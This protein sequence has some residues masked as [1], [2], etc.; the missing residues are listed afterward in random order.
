MPAPARAVVPMGQHLGR[1]AKA[2]VKRRETVLRGQLLG[3]AQ[4]FISANVHSPISGKVKDVGLYRGPVGVLVECVVIEAD[5][6]DEAV[7]FEARDSSALSGAE[8][9]ERVK[10]AGITGMGG[11][12][13][14]ANVKLTPPPGRTIHT[15]LINGCECEP[16]LT[17]DHALMT[18]RPKDVLQGARIL[19]KALGAKRV[20]IGIEDNKPDAAQALR[21]A[22]AGPDIEVLELAVK[23]PQGAEKQL[24][25][26][27]LGVEVPSGGLPL[28]VGVVVHNVA[29]A[30]AVKE[31]VADGKP[32]YERILTV[33]GDAVAE[34]GNLLVRVG[35]PFSEA[36]AF[37]GG[38]RGTVKK[39]ISGGP[40]MGIA[41]SDLDVPVTK[42][43]SGILLFTE[44][45]GRG[46][47]VYPCLRCGRCIEACPMGLRPSVLSATAEAGRWAD[48]KGLDLLDCMECGS[49]VYACPANR[50]L[51]QSIRRGKAEVQKL[52]HRERQREEEKKKDS[53][54]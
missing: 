4:G 13:F 46:P 40:M 33:T 19:Q 10:A 49:C 35:T 44:K 6:R 26:A 36:V 15:L 30:A 25:W 5:G 1:P 41:Q 29:T 37:C 21:D 9:V 7:P 20:V 54:A 16:C 50:R 12:T 24:I 48:L 38:T 39:I 34:P 45:E 27:I 8:I 22:G 47:R 31:A 32:L 52:A 51:V 14:P 28:D 18:A 3:E 53:E 43:T 2:L 23:Y 17:A 42:G 11:A